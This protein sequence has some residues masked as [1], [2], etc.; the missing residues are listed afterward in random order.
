MYETLHTGVPV[1]RHGVTGNAVVRVSTMPNVFAL[2]TAHGLTTAAAAYYWFSELYNRAPFEPVDDRQVD[3]AALPIQHGRFYTED[4]FP[5]REVIPIA[6]GLLRRYRP[7]YLLV[8]PMGMDYVGE[9]HGSDSSQYR[10]QATVQDSLLGVMVPEWLGAGY[11]VLV[12]GDHGVNSDGSHGGTTPDVRLVPLYLI[13]PEGRGRGDTRVT[14][15]QLQLAPTVC[16]LLGLP[17]PETMT[18][19]PVD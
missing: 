14:V 2:A 11:T 5:D 7:D 12:T 1:S 4:G 17:I 16:R 3:D 18:H 9:N 10:T 15:S 6:A 13:P 8:H 19:P